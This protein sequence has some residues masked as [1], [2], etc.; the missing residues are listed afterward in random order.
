MALWGKWKTALKVPTNWHRCGTQRSGFEFVFNLYAF[1]FLSKL[2]AY[3]DANCWATDV[4]F[5]F[6]L[7]DKAGKRR[8]MKYKPWL[9]HKRTCAIIWSQKH[10]LSVM[11]ENIHITLGAE[12]RSGAGAEDTDGLCIGE[13]PTWHCT[14]EVKTI[15]GVSTHLLKTYPVGNIKKEIRSVLSADTHL[16]NAPLAS[17]LFDITVVSKPNASN[18]R[19]NSNL[20]RAWTALY[21][22]CSNYSQSAWCVNMIWSPAETCRGSGTA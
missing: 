22:Y 12:V 16:T 2:L 7:V 9:H 19:I 11:Y 3:S 4:F 20:M 5:W 14:S 17:C 1:L 10:P 6:N 21:Y 8:H 13:C 18:S 15:P